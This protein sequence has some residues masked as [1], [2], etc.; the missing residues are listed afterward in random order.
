MFVGSN[1]VLQWMPGSGNQVVRK[2]T[3]M[4]PGRVSP[5]VLQRGVSEI[6]DLLFILGNN[7]SFYSFRLYFW[8]SILVSQGVSTTF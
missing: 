1:S 8:R 6:Y 5:C 3:K 7:I 4:S 2:E